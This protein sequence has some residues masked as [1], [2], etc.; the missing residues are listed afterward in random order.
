MHQRYYLR[1]TGKVQGVFFRASTQQ[2]ALA[3]Q[4]TGWVR[5]EPDGA[6][7][8]EIEG[9]EEACQAMIRWCHIGPVRAEVTQVTCTPLPPQGGTDF[10]IVRK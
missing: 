1:I 10:V 7:S 3:L 4:L 9:P 6:V 2:Q 8:T 5:N